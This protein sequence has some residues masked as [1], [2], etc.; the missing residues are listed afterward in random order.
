MLLTMMDG[1]EGLS[2]VYVLAATSRPDLIDP[3]LLRPGRLDKSLIC[4]MPGLDDRLEILRAVSA[5]LHVDPTVLNDDG[6]DNSGQG[7]SQTLTEVARRTA[8]YSG[9]D[10]QAVMYNAHL[11]AIHDVLGADATAQEQDFGKRNGSSSSAS[12]KPP[13][14]DF[15]YFRL[16]G[17]TG[18][19]N[20]PTTTAAT[21]ATERAQ[22]ASKLSAMQLAR[23]KAR[24]ERHPHHAGQPLVPSAVNGAAEEGKQHTEPVVVIG[25]RHLQKSLE[26]TRAS[27]SAQEQSRL[28]RIYKEFV[29]GR[30]GEMSDGQ[31]STEIGGRTS[32]M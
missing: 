7:P 3:A 17:E 24:Q 1:A 19:E 18:E 27:I 9:A 10:L 23:R 14:Q 2:G 22:I 12:S 32:L 15:T 5:K 20:N 29:V 26:T 28:A 31:G 21:T 4:D 13:P 16:G 30:N 8:R 6:D 11:E 25:W